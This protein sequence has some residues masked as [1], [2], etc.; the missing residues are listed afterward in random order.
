MTIELVLSTVIV[1]VIYNV[2][3]LVQLSLYRRRFAR[4]F[5]LDDG[6]RCSLLR[7]GLSCHAH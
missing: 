4:G 7:L 6:S 3:L 1:R 2:L 5:V